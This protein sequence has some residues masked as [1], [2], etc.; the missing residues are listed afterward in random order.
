MKS[1]SLNLLEP[2]GSV[3]T[4]TG[5]VLSLSLS[6][7]SYGNHIDFGVPL[8]SYPMGIAVFYSVLKRLKR[9]GKLSPLPTLVV[10][11]ARHLIS[12]FSVHLL[13]LIA[14]YRDDM[15]L[16]FFQLFFYRKLL[17]FIQC[18]FTNILV[19]SH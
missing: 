7:L 14:R 12:M 13:G 19:T 10:S 1:G 5:I 4:C 6:F 18:Q 11:N 9:E 16:T 3:Q 17:T 8:V 2:P 15:I